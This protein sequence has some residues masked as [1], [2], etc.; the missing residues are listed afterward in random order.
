M[1]FEF[2][3]PGRLIFG[4]G[5]IASVG[6]A[7]AEYGRHV[8]IVTGRRAMQ[9]CGVLDRVRASLIEAGV[10]STVFAE[11][12]SNPTIDLVD[13]G[14]Q[15]AREAGC[16]VVLGLGGGSAMDSA[17]AIAIAGRHNRPIREF[18]VAEQGAPATPTA[19]TLPVICATSTAGTSSELTAIAVLTIPDLRQ[20]SAIRNP[21]ILP[22]VA[23]ED[24]ELT[25]SVSPE[26]TAATGI[27]VL[28]HA[29]EAYINNATTP[30]HDLM[31]EEAIRLV[32]RYL[33]RVYRDGRDV[34][35][36]R[37]MMLA[38]T[39]AGYGLACCGATVMH[40]MEHPISAH[41]PEVAHGVGLAA[42]IRPWARRLWPLM[43]ER[44]ARITEL[45]G[46]DV[47][48]MP[49]EQAARQ[50]ETVLGELLQT[51]GLQVRLRDL[52]IER[53]KLPEMAADTCRYMTVTINKT[54]GVPS[55]EEIVEMLQEAY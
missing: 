43:P 14:G 44:F 34:E 54:P 16:D 53:D 15:V 42:V 17:K 6:E 36:R 2:R 35:G 37:Q 31:S 50:A 52:G 49:V 40:G 45:L 46:R 10:H 3:P 11:V 38:N 13:R 30:L 19:A 25:Y 23:I 32:G 4:E 22:R 21:L 29:M 51:V 5:A 27:D 20:K 24:P 8:L 28:C 9:E 55:C 47:S 48:G 18:M 41:H 12:T 33:P 7:V 39:Y 26:V 1:L